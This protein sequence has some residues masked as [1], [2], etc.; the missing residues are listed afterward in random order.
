MPQ[1]APEALKKFLIVF[2]KKNF[3]AGIDLVGALRVRARRRR[4]TPNRTAV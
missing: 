1:T 3:S 4:R 2:K